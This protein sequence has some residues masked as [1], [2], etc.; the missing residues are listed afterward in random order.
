[1]ECAKYF[2]IFIIAGLSCHGNEFFA[3]PKR[4]CPNPIAGANKNSAIRDNAL[5]LFV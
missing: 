4:H 5:F 2:I 1:M 3:F